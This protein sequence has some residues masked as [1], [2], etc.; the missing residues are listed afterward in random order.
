M[1]DYHHVKLSKV[2]CTCILLRWYWGIYLMKDKVL[3]ILL[4][5]WIV[6][7]CAVYPL[8]ALT[9]CVSLFLCVL[10][11]SK[12]PLHKYSFVGPKLSGCL[13]FVPF[14]CYWAAVCSANMSLIMILLFLFLYVY[15]EQA[16]ELFKETVNSVAVIR[17]E[18]V[19]YVRTSLYCH[20][21]CMLCTCW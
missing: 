4:A 10:T 9:Q 18:E 7:Q 17:Q 6:K 3:F 15:P 16:R 1:Y 13:N 14:S 19:Q 21:A 2:Y 11:T 20:C 5:H 8:W 12:F